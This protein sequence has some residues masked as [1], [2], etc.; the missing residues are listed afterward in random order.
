MRSTATVLLAVATLAGCVSAPIAPSR[1]EQLAMRVHLY[2]DVMSETLIR[3]AEA[4]LQ[5]GKKPGIQIQDEPNGFTAFVPYFESVILAS[6]SGRYVWKFSS[7][8]GRAEVSLSKIGAAST[9]VATPVIGGY[10]GLAVSS[11]NAAAAAPINSPDAYDLFWGR[12]DYLLGRRADWPKCR[13][14]WAAAQSHTRQER[15]IDFYGL[16]GGTQEYEAPPPPRVTV[17]Q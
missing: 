16:C 9:A 10:G 8:E 14:A 13:D 11:I 15:T 5:A 2:P 4:V 1:D 12:L 3:G 17:N 6:D 7:S